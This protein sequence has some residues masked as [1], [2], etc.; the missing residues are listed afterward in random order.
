MNTS[1]LSGVELKVGLGREDY[2]VGVKGPPAS[3]Q[4]QFISVMRQWPAGN[5]IS[6]EAEESPL[7]ETVTR[8]RLVKTVTD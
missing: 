2:E 6:A 7:L 4:V 5:G 3:Y 8:R 1:Q